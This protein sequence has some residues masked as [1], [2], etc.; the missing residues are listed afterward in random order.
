MRRS[1]PKLRLPEGLCKNQLVS[2]GHSLAS[3]ADQRGDN[4]HCSGQT[5]A[6]RQPSHQVVDTTCPAWNV[7]GSNGYC[8]DMFDMWRLLAGL[9]GTA[10]PR[11]AQSLSVPP[12]AS[13]PATDGSGGGPMGSTS[14]LLACLSDEDRPLGVATLFI[15]TYGKARAH[16]V[17]DSRRREAKAVQR[18]VILKSCADAPIY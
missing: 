18:Q 10:L 6:S 11:I 1:S 5:V 13:V 2:R 3:S 9:L 4:E 7:A 15:A 14:S 12:I 16:S 17:A 8:R